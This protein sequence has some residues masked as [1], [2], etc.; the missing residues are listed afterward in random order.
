MSFN[1][2]AAVTVCT[3]F[4]GQEKKIC[5][6]FSFF[7]YICHKVMAPDAMILVFASFLIL[8]HLK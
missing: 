4:G 5:H 2:I 1:F 8:S 7:P 3:D 6:S